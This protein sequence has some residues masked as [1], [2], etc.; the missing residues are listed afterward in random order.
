MVS[1]MHD[2]C[3]FICILFQGKHVGHLAPLTLSKGESKGTP[4]W[5]QRGHGHVKEE[6]G[7]HP[8]VKGPWT[9]WCQWTVLMMQDTKEGKEEWCQGSF[10][11]GSYLL[12]LSTIGW[13]KLISS[14]Q[15]Q[16]LIPIPIMSAS[17]V[18]VHPSSYI[19]HLT[20]YTPQLDLSGK[21]PVSCI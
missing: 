14:S 4:Y 17:F 10:Y 1:P 3:L 5:K 18:D 9:A 21:V 12:S 7:G 19:V 2:N 8:K 20:Q 11:L 16:C 6:G 13:A 15:S